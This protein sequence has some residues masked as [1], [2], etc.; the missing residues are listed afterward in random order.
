MLGSLF[1][2][3]MFLF[4]ALFKLRDKIMNKAKTRLS[5]RLHSSKVRQ[6]TE[7]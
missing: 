6:K 2:P 1:I 3:K 7:K 5:L 4:Q